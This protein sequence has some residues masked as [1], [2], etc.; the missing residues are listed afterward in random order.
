ML[1]R[2]Q[3]L[4][5]LHAAAGVH[6]A[7]SKESPFT[8]WCCRYPDG[9]HE[10]MGLE[11]LLPLLLRRGTAGTAGAA[12]GAGKRRGRPPKQQR[13]QRQQQW[14]QEEASDE[15]TSDEEEE[16]EEE[17]EEEEEPRRRPGR[18]PKQ[19]VQR[20]QRAQQATLTGGR[21]RRP[22]SAVAAVLGDA[23][24]VSVWVP[25]E[26]S[27]EALEAS[28]QPGGLYE[29]GG[30]GHDRHVYAWDSEWAVFCVLKRGN[31]AGWLSGAGV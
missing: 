13:R 31:V 6:T 3:G 9:D 5:P 18:Q 14:E 11:S 10:D 28:R 23:S 8:S 16:A 25:L 24:S 30:A 15:E 26:P 27:A 22:S 17:E 2:E 20:A 12:R 19:Q 21:Q 4:G 7:T 29:A 1:R